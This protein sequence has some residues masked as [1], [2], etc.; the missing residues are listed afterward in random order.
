MLAVQLFW[1]QTLQQAVCVGFREEHIRPC[2]A[3]SDADGPEQQIGGESESF[4]TLLVFRIKQEGVQLLM[5][6]FVDFPEVV[7]Y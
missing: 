3:V 4:E 7:A 2:D 5:V 6:L 1:S